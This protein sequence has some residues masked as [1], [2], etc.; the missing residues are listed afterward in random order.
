[1]FSGTDLLVVDLVQ[2]KVASAETS[3]DRMNYYEQLGIDPFAK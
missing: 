1:M 3:S 2:L